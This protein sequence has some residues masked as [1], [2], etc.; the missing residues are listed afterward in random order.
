[1]TVFVAPDDA[2]RPTIFAGVPL[3]VSVSG[4]CHHR[5]KQVLKCEL[6]VGA[7]PGVHR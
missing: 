3:T 5:G 2:A 4:C 7:T 6:R 1:M